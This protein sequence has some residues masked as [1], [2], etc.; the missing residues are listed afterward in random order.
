VSLVRAWLLNVPFHN[1]DLLA[2]SLDGCRSLSAE[3]AVERCVEGLG[4]PCHVNAIG[5]ASLL[6]ACGFDAGL[7]GATVGQPGDHLLVRVTISGGTYLCDVG[8]GQPYLSPFKTDRVTEVTHLGWRAR[9][10]P[11]GA[12]IRLSRWSPDLPNGKI[13]YHATPEPRTWADFAEVIAQHHS[14]PGFGPFMTGLRAVRIGDDRI[15]TLRDLQWTVYEADSF[16]VHEVPDGGVATL[17]VDVFGLSALP[18]ERALKAWRLARSGVR[19]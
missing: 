8:N 15:D 4:G 12:G 18:I 5:F 19:R 13:V 1:L 3:E 10:E 6:T 2:A 7:C 16:Q 9:A 11:C 17:L 14:R